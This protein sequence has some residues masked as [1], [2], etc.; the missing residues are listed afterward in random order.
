[1]P[2]LVLLTVD[3][4][5][6]ELEE[7]AVSLCVAAGV[8]LAEAPAVRLADAEPEEDGV[9]DAELVADAVA[10]LEAVCVLV[11]VRVGVPEIELVVVC[12]AEAVGDVEGVKGAHIPPCSFPPQ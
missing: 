9:L 12:V 11:A 1:M 10:E 2:E 5:E 7:V 4:G 6:E 8:P 3:E